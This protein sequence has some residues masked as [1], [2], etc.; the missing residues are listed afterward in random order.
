MPADSET[1]RILT[2]LDGECVFGP[3]KGKKLTL[4]LTLKQLGTH[5]KK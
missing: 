1:E 5:G 4:F 2:Q 3:R